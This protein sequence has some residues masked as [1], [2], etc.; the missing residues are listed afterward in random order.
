[1]GFSTKMA[2]FFSPDHW[3]FIE[4]HSTLSKHLNNKL[5]KKKKDLFY[6]IAWCQICSNQL[7]I[8]CLVSDYMSY[9]KACKI[10]VWL[11]VYKSV[12]F[13][14][15]WGG[16]VSA[17]EMSRLPRCLQNFDEGNWIHT[18]CYCVITSQVQMWFSTN[19]QVFFRNSHK[20]KLG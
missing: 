1:M 15:W 7:N 5:Q 6:V 19:N 14:N 9:S 3:I 16:F 20:M 17:V 10:F 18:V 13:S 8:R 11:K 12:S 2:H 4:C